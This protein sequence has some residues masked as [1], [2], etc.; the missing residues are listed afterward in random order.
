MV[1]NELRRLGV[2]SNYTTKE[3]DEDIATIHEIIK[4]TFKQM[5]KDKVKN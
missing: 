2:E 1:F 3:A 5:A 4:D